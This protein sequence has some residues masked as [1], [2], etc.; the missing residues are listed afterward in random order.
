LR[1]VQLRSISLFI[2]VYEISCYIVFASNSCVSNSLRYV[3]PCRDCTVD[4][5]TIFKELWRSHG[6]V[7]T[8]FEN[9]RK[10]KYIAV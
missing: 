6:N 9:W 7:N 4:A 5:I 2:C 1:E 10:R 3:P 8:F